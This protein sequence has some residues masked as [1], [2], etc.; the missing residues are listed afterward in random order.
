MNTFYEQ[1]EKTLK[2][3]ANT[4]RLRIT[5]IQAEPKLNLASNDYLG[6]SRNP[7]VL[8]GAIEALAK[9]GS[10]SS[11]SP[12]VASYLTIH[13]ELENFLSTWIG[14]P[15]SLLWSS[16]YAANYN[17]TAT[18]PQKG[19]LIVADRLMHHSA[20]RG[21]MDSEARLMRFP[22]NDLQAL[23]TLLEKHSPHFKTIFILTESLYSM[24]G[25]SPD[26]QSLANLKNRFPFIWIL[27][28]AHAIGWYGP[29]GNGL[30]A[31][32]GVTESVDILITTLGKALASQGACSLFQQESLRAYCVNF[33]KEFMYTTYPS[34]ANTGAAMAA[35]SLITNTLSKSSSQWKQE[36]LQFKENLQALFPFIEKND[37]PILPIILRSDAQ[38]LKAGQFLREHGILTGRIRP[39]SVP[40]GLSRLRLSLNSTINA[41]LWSDLLLPLLK[42]F[43]TL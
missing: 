33:A 28:E 10:S 39:P 25:D 36:T 35:G 29:S 16:G 8:Q 18:L 38:T 1:I 19:D 9:Y 42:N 21:A 20:L 37:S 3:C 26:L 15:Y 11:G 2:N 27:D 22:H 4:S 12:V 41:Q 5:Q 24:D 13:E 17:I 31:E 14:L 34:P 23:E 40:I 30:A 32:H 6:L 43:S 7:L